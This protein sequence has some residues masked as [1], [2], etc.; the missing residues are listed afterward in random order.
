MNTFHFHLTNV[1]VVIIH[2]PFY[3][4]VGTLFNKSNLSK[5]ETTSIS[6]DA[7]ASYNTRGNCFYL[8]LSS[9]SKFIRSKLLFFVSVNRIR[10]SRAAFFI[11]EEDF[12][13]QC[14]QKI[15]LLSFVIFWIFLCFVIEKEKLSAD[16]LKLEIKSIRTSCWKKSCQTKKN[17][18][19]LTK[20]LKDLK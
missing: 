1:L 13:S 17:K 3:F 14:Y 5:S 16:I 19:D 7:A 8:N 10:P 2:C 20:D 9:I 11:Q 6:K 12:S 18:N 15:K 4:F